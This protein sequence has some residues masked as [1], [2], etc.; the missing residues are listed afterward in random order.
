M[1][2]DI[3]GEVEE[4]E[5]QMR[6]AKYASK[7]RHKRASSTKSNSVLTFNQLLNQIKANDIQALQP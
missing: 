4:E 6:F 1:L 7:Y 5:N 2:N 3:K